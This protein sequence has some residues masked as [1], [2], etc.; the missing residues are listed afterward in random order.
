MCISDK[1]V[2]AVGIGEQPLTDSVTRSLQIKPTPEPWAEQ[3]EQWQDT[4]TQLAQ[5][6]RDGGATVTPQKGACRY[7]HLQ[8]LCRI[9]TPFEE[10]AD[11]EF[12]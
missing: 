3:R 1:E 5:A 12:D 8:G 11:H 2:K 4:L 6:L 10:D 7:C 9:N